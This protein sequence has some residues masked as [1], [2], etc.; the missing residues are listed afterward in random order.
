V[1]AVADVAALGP[2]AVTLPKVRETDEGEICVPVPVQTSF[3]G[4][5]DAS[6]LKV[7]VPLRM[8]ITG[9]VKVTLTVQLVPAATVVP[10]VLAL[11]VKSPLLMILLIFSVPD[12]VFV[13]LTIFAVLVVPSTLLP[14]ARFVTD[15]VT[16]GPP[17]P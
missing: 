6:S 3:C 14:N 7:N 5:V 1:V 17:P 8:P 12:P 16:A 15:R 10:Q 2:R 13:S 9:G 4:L 11:M